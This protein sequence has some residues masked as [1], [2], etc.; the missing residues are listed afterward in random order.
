MGRQQQ[1]RQIQKS[2]GSK[3]KA[4][5]P[6]KKL[7]PKEL[8]RRSSV[9]A[10]QQLR[11]QLSKRQALSSR[12]HMHKPL[13]NTNTIFTRKLLK[14]QTEKTRQ[15]ILEFDNERLKYL[16][17]RDL[18]EDEALRETMELVHSHY[19]GLLTDREI[20]RER[21]EILMKARAQ[22]RTLPASETRKSGLRLHR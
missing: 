13:I 16:L 22:Q 17:Q 10:A 6:L 1:V 2:R 21:L 4:Q 15:R 9:V 14:N 18:E 19:N 3:A 5:I 20:G 12:K 11:N 7:D 8:R